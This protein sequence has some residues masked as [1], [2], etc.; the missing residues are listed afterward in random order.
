MKY[1][2]LVE[3]YLEGELNG[4]DLVK[5]ELEILTKPEVAEEVERVRSLNRF[6]KEQHHRMQSSSIGLVEDFEDLENILSE[7]EVGKELEGLRIRKISASQNDHAELETRLTE[8][9][10]R[11]TLNQRHSNKV[12]VKKVSI[13][14]AAASLAVL[15]GISSILIIGRGNNDY[16]QLYQQF[17]SPPIADIERTSPE[18]AD[19]PYQIALKAYNNAEYSRA[20]QLL[21][22]IP[23]EGI[24]NRYYLYKGITAMELGK[25]PLA[26]E[27]FKRLDSDVYLRHEAMW[28]MSLCYLGLEDEISTR[29]MLNE[30]IQADGYYKN[31]ARTL[32]RKI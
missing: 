2:W 14:M 6:V 5:F 12:L 27:S 21:N 20:F 30:I 15:I 17:Y 24:N 4:E 31:M 25:F 19:D 11:D 29:R 18:L 23:E 13:W 7:E 3:K 28:F 26:I 10:I 16:S 1:T 8:S 9:H 32:L 22:S